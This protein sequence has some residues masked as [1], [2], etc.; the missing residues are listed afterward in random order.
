MVG[1][2]EEVVDVVVVA[3]HHVI[4]VG[5]PAVGNEA[6]FMEFEGTIATKVFGLGETE[7]ADCRALDYT[8]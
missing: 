8:H 2:A 6:L 1:A 4:E 5:G 7:L 3:T